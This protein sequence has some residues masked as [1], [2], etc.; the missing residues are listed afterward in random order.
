MADGNSFAARQRRPERD[1]LDLF[2]AL[3]GDLAPSDAQDLSGYPSFSLAKSE[4]MVPIEVWAGRVRSELKRCRNMAWATI[5]DA[6]VSIRAASQ[7][8]EARDAGLKT[9]RLMAATPDENEILTAVG[10]CTGVRNDGRLPKS[11]F[12]NTDGIGE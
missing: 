2:R 5:G 3:P 11:R 4:R 6:A 8:V 7:I 9:S 1:Q 12:N 10:R